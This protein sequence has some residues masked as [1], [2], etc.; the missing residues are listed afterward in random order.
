[1]F[2]LFHDAVCEP[3]HTGP[4]LV[5]ELVD[6]LPGGVLVT[7][8]ELLDCA[9]AHVLGLVVGLAQGLE[10]EVELT[11]CL[12]FLSLGDDGFG[13]LVL[14]ERCLYGGDLVLGLGRGLELL[15]LGLKVKKEG[16]GLLNCLY[17]LGIELVLV[18]GKALS[19]LLLELF[20]LL[21]PLILHG[22]SALN[23]LAA[24]VLGGHGVHSNTL[25][26]E[27]LGRDL[28]HKLGLTDDLD[29]LDALLVDEG[30]K[31]RDLALVLDD[32]GRSLLRHGRHRD[33]VLEVDTG[34]DHE[35]AGDALFDKL[36]DD[37]LLDLLGYFL[38][39]LSRDKLD[40]YIKCLELLSDISIECLT[41]K[42]DLAHTQIG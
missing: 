13:G 9:P 30:H 35:Q 16:F 41:D 34:C 10:R 6:L 15:E 39:V 27:E 22:L 36:V 29:L 8:V 5:Q 14:L 42:V 1:M 3:A 2:E 37:L 26:K 33:D 18:L 40:L 32:L 24:N 17:E 7:S 4:L 12:G 19:G 23:E 38:G 25:C 21:G 28:A 31:V 20:A 11:S